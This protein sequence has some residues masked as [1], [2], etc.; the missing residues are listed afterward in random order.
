MNISCQN[1]SPLRRVE[2]GGYDFQI[3]SFQDLKNARSI[4]AIHTP[5]PLLFVKSGYPNLGDKK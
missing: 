5:G 4:A 2:N 1:G 3:I